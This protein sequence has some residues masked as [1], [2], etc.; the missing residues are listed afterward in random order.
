MLPPG[1]DFIV[2]PKSGAV[3]LGLAEVRAE[4]ERVKAVL[5]KRC[6]E[7]LARGADKHHVSARP[8]PRAVRK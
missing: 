7:A 4:W 5:D 3:A 2:I 8:P 1:V 6:M